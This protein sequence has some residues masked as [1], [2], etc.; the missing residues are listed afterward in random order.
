MIKQAYID[1]FI[2]KCAEN[3]I[4]GNKLLKKA[5]FFG[6]FPN[7][8][9][10]LGPSQ[11][12]TDPRENQIRDAIKYLSSTYDGYGL[13]KKKFIDSASVSKGGTRDYLEKV[14]GND[15]RYVYDALNSYVATR[16]KEISSMPHR[17]P[18][19]GTA[20]YMAALKNGITP[21]EMIKYD[22]QHLKDLPRT[23]LESLP[24]PPESKTAPKQS[25]KPIIA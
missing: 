19:K 23:I 24:K 14:F 15:W 11:V 10:F 6:F 20:A 7:I 1:G 18:I 12:R 5:I 4:D 21:E 2:Q 22:K 3:G 9:S 16:D 25:D 13:F 17:P 8:G